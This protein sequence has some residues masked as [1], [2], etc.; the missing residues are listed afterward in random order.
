VIQTSHDRRCATQRS[1]SRVE[2]GGECQDSPLHGDGV[3]NLSDRLLPTSYGGVR[4]VD[5]SPPNISPI[6]RDRSRR[7]RPPRSTG[8]RTI[9]IRAGR[10]APPRHWRA[11]HA[12]TRHSSSADALQHCLVSMDLRT[13]HS[14]RDAYPA[15]ASS[16]TFPHPNISSAAAT[17]RHRVV[18]PLGGSFGIRA[19]AIA[20][21][22]DDPERARR[23]ATTV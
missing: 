9:S 17:V 14:G 16:A 12:A 10:S 5:A 6:E 18:E 2:V 15:C 20:S 3:T 21:E 7:G 23:L 11:D 13:D 22:L 1:R 4:P 8:G 19:P